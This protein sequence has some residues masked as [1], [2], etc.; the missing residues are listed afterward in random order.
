MMIN[1]VRIPVYT[2]L[3]YSAFSNGKAA[4]GASEYSQQEYSRIKRK[5]D[6]YLLPLMWICYGI[7]QAD[8]V[9]LSTQ[10]TFGLREVSQILI[11]IAPRVIQLEYN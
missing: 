3:M 5:A 6:R 1:S 10:A 11:R 4:P 9:S 7:Q 8:K 2:S